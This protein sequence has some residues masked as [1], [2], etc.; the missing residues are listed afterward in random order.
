[1]FRFFLPLGS[2]L[3]FL[4]LF[5]PFKLGSAIIFQ[6]STFHKPSPKKFP[7][8]YFVE[9]TDSSLKIAGNF[10]EI[11]PNHFHAGLDVKT[12]GREGTFVLA[13]ADGYVSRIKISAFGYGKC[14]YITHPNGF[15]TV[16]AHLQR[17][18]GKLAQYLELE[19]Y[20]LESFEV[21]LTVD[22]TL[23]KVK[24][25]DTIAI[26]GNT[27]GSQSPHLHFEVRDAVTE[28][29]Y[30]PF[31]FGYKIEDTVPPK[32]SLLK[33]YPA[34]DSSSINGKN[35]AKKISVG[36]W[37]G[38]Y[39]IAPQKITVNGNIGF[40]IETTDYSNIKEAGK[41]G[42]YSIEMDIDGK[43]IYYHELNEIGFDESRYINSHIDY[44]EEAKSN[45]EIQKCFVDEANKLSIYQC[46]VNHGLFLFNDSSSHQV[47]FIVKDFFQNASGLEFG[48]RSSVKKIKTLPTP[49]SQLLTKMKCNEENKFETND[50][51]IDIP[52][53]SLYENIDFDYSISKDTLPGTFSAVHSIHYSNVPVHYAYTLSIKTK[54]L[55]EKLQSKATLVLLDGNNNKTDQKGEYKDGWVS[56]QTK[57][58]GRY[59][60]TLDTVPPSIKPYNIYN[61]K[62][63]SKAKTI[64]VTIGDNL[65]NIKSYRATIDGKWILMQ[66]EYKKGMLFYEFDERISKGKHFIEITVADGK[67]NARTYKA[68]FT[69]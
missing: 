33:I 6:D 7:Q 46:A 63:M 35:E 34:D 13:A 39:H 58:F 42:A 22:S 5:L 27:G 48:V 60:V 11:R 66:Y 29:A 21:D 19:Q 37:R 64:A 41:L 17:L 3:L 43:R 23:L 40:G 51:K 65:T 57:Y 15:V 31:L 12:G 30:N 1:M 56:T 50:M 2:G 69:R 10:G 62:N 25:C 16:Y 54:L 53:C 61:G 68:E 32:I 36:G 44:A 8:G 45:K 9:P 49:N 67:D 24:Q 38:K 20:R 4:F 18:Y 59:T 28:H 47:K 14:L 26:S 55:P 52:P